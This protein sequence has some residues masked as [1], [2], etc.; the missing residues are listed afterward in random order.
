[1]TDLP[2]PTV[3]LTP[4]RGA[5]PRAGGRVDAL[6]RIEVG[7]PGVE[8]D[9]D[10]V[11][12]ALVID[13]SGSMGG[14]P[15]AYAKRAAQQALTVLQPGDAVAVVAFDSGVEVVVPTIAVTDDRSHVHDAIER[16]R[17]GGMTALHGGWVEGLTQALALEHAPGM[18]RVVLLSD[19]QAN[20]GE[21]SPAEIAADVAKAFA[22]HGVSTSAVGLGAHFD[23]RLMS[24]ISTAGGGTFTFVETPQQLPELFETEI[25]SLS[26][27]R[28]RRV[29]LAFDGAAARFVAAGGGARLDAG[30]LGFPDLV[31]GMPRDA[32]VTIELDALTALPPLRLSWDDTYTGARESLDV[33]LD[34]PL[35]DADELAARPVEPTVAAASRGRTYADA[36]GRIEPLVRRGRFD[37]A[38][39]AITSLREQVESWPRDEAREERLQDLAQLLERSRARDQAMSAKV[40]HDMKYRV[41]TDMPRSKRAAMLAV[42]RDLRSDKM[43]FREAARTP[44]RPAR[45]PDPTAPLGIVRPARTVHRAEVAHAD[46]GATRLEVVIGDITKQEADAIVN[47]SNR[48]LFGTAGVDGA[49]H[50]TG[51]PELTAACRA[52]GGIDYGQAV[53]TPGFRLAATHVIH[54]TT[55]R[56]RGGNAGELAMLER[57]YAASLDAARRLRVH[58]LALPAIGTG[59]FRYPLDQATEVA[60]ATVI[61]AVAKH[62]APQVVRFVVLGEQLAN[63]YARALAAA[64]PAAVPA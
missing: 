13:R 3:S 24:A 21:T 28:G 17:V 51:G 9:R 32:L 45:I 63:T 41:D 50:A 25:A 2:R 52:I 31:G 23:E 15:L 14:E 44:P 1:M 60:V 33:T 37:D 57:A 58:T 7:L 34:L 38:E 8:R 35:L 46:G 59:S 36:L 48:G 55:P 56:W 42:E 53:V 27:L 19:G 4:E 62:E 43:A 26:S 40:A 29:R 18:A 6:L 16:I 61:A 12:L 5:V 10:A 30:H 54:T 20:V 22:V 11:T 47:P 64:L 39:R 49:V